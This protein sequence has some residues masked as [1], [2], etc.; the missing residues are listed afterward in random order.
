MRFSTP[1]CT[2][3]FART[4]VTSLTRRSSFEI[5]DDG[6]LVRSSN[7]AI[8]IV[9]LHALVDRILHF[10][11]YLFLAGHLGGCKLYHRIRRDLYWPALAVYWNATVRKCPHSARK[12][13]KIQKNVTELQLFR[14]TSPLLSMRID[15]LGEFIIT[16]RRNDYLLL[17]TDWCIKI[18]KTVPM[19]WISAV[20]RAIQFINS[21]VLNYG[22]TEKL[23]AN[24]DGC[25]TSK[26]FIYACMII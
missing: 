2:T 1:N 22:P 19:K 26:C 7:K 16:Q 9:I 6:N 8:Q 17:I 23:I 15:I 24:N 13:I 18:K 3:C 25:F 14:E 21:V 5:D 10:S 4:Y 12:R 20:Y 11:Y